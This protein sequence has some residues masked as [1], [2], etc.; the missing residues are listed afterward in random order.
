MLN[1]AAVIR[2]LL[3]ITRK[4]LSAI[5]LDVSWE[6]QRGMLSVLVRELYG[7]IR[8]IERELE[9]A[10]ATRERYHAPVCVGEPQPQEWEPIDDYEEPD[11]LWE[12]DNEPKE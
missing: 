8:A 2:E 6:S 11:N 3:E 1:D 5:N 9:V 7:H 4:A 10:R 12:D